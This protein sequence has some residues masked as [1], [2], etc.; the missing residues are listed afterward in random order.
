VRLPAMQT[1]RGGVF[2]ERTGLTTGAITGLLDRLEKAGFVRRVRDPEDRRRIIIDPI[3]KNLAVAED[4]FRSIGE[5]M[6]KLS[7]EFTPQEMALVRRVIQ[8]RVEITK[9]E[10]SRLREQ[11]IV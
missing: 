2:A 4:L 10:I 8:R 11:S 7:D 3:E 9:E 1:I 5:S 6:A